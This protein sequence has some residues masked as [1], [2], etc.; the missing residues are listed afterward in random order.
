MIKAA[1]KHEKPVVLSAD[2]VDPN[3]RGRKCSLEPAAAGAASALALQAMPT[4]RAGMMAAG[5]SP[6][7]ILS[8]KR[9]RSL[10]VLT[11]ASRVA[12]SPIV[13]A[14][15]CHL[16]RGVLYLG[17]GVLYLGYYSFFVLDWL[18]DLKISAP[19]SI[20]LAVI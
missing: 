18:Q 3:T 8:N 9:S 5:M 16:G 12:S 11:R 10:P 2:R 7:P 20:R 15:C 14:G 6:F 17:R 13:S 19:C 4:D 1:V